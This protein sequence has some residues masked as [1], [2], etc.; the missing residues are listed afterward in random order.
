MDLVQRAAHLNMEGASYLEEDDEQ[1]A[2]ISFN[3]AL[4]CMSHAA[5]HYYCSKLLQQVAAAASTPVE[6]PADGS[7]PSTNTIPLMAIPKPHES[8]E[9]DQMEFHADDDSADENPQHFIY[10]QALVFNPEVARNPVDSLFYSAVIIFNTALAFHQRGKCMDPS[11]QLKAAS[12]YDISLDLLKESATRFNC[13]NIIVGALNN[14]AH[15]YFKLGDF[16]KARSVLDQLLAV[17]ISIKGSPPAF[18]ETDVQGILHNIL[19][20]H[21]ASYAAAA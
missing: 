21:S 18:S 7:P 16:H 17:M 14:K 11:A 8:D 20:L 4:E 10:S 12:L 5:G 19:L 3:N 6:T 13:S 1:R 15:L 9:S 2:L